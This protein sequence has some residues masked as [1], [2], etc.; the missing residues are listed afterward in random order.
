MPATR[1]AGVTPR[2]GE[3]FFVLSALRD[4]PKANRRRTTTLADRVLHSPP[5][6]TGC[7]RRAAQRRSAPVR[8]R[9]GS[10]GLRRL[11]PID[12]SRDA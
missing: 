9:D 3:S 6:T 1:F 10:L 11:D 5:E 4:M 12:V 2:R 8:S 7:T